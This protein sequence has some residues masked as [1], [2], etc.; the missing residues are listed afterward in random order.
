MLNIK[1]LDI[2]NLRAMKSELDEQIKYHKANLDTE[3]ALALTEQLTQINEV[4]SDKMSDY[5]QMLKS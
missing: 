3:K 2:A 1:D 5:G 4:I